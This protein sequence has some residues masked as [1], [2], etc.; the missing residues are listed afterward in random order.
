MELY[1]KK[2]LHGVYTKHGLARGYAKQGLAQGSKPSNG[3]HGAPRKAEVYLE[4]CDKARAHM[5]LY[6]KPEITRGFMQS[7]VS[8]GALR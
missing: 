4:L 1:D 6:T 7:K 2:D 5:G 8:H 3:L